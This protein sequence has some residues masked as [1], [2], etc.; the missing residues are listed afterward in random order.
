MAESPLPGKWQKI[1]I[2]TAAGIFL[3]TLWLTFIFTDRSRGNVSW[4]YIISWVVIVILYIGLIINGVLRGSDLLQLT[5]RLIFIVVFVMEVFSST[6][7]SYGVP[8]NFN[9]PLTHLDAFYFMLGTLSTAGTGTINATS[10]LARG[11]QAVQMAV[12]LGLVVF[13]VSLVVSRFVSSK[14]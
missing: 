1:F 4:P 11:L 6:Y 3:A 8:P 10:E 13:A 12:D 5:F 2:R 7:W 9:I 14:S